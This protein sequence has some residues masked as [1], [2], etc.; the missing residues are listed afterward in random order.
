MASKST[1]RVIWPSLAFVAVAA[2]LAS[3][4]D[5]LT[6]MHATIGRALVAFL[7]AALDRKSVV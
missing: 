5:A 1:A 4:L 6:V 3:Y 7:V 2:G